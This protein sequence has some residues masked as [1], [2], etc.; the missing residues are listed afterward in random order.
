MGFCDAP[1]D[2]FLSFL[3]ARRY[4]SELLPIL[5]TVRALRNLSGNLR[6]GLRDLSDGIS[7]VTGRIILG[8]HAALILPNP[9]S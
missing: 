6:A 5:E 9:S 3:D 4:F 2:F 7:N 8:T 1:T